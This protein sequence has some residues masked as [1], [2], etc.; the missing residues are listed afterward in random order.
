MKKVFRSKYAFPT[1]VVVMG[2]KGAVHMGAEAAAS[3]IRSVEGVDV[4]SDSWRP[5]HTKFQWRWFKRDGK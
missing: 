3:D 1:R 4:T 2:A 5:R